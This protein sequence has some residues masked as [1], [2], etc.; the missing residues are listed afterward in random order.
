[1]GVGD[2][3]RGFLEREGDRLIVAQLEWRRSS[4]ARLLERMNLE[5]R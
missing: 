1:M 3:Q 4:R 2:I 5:F